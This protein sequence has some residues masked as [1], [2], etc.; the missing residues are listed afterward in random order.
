[1]KKIILLAMHGAPPRDFPAREMAELFS[2]HPRIEHAP[3]P[4]RAGLEQRY[5]ELD[6]RMRAWPRTAENDPFWAGTQELADQLRRVTGLEVV[7]GFNE[8]CAPTLDEA[9]DQ[10][11]ALAA[12]EV[13]VVTPM[14]TRG[15]EHSE[16]DIPAAVRAAQ[17]RHP[18][19][20]IRY[21]W[22]FDMSEV[23]QFLAAQI[24][25]SG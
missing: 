20:S 21:V 6:A 18:A 17:E 3:E 19:L 9:F 14:M 25:R 16:S 8:F 24:R 4:E 15:G 2:L 23:A 13:I 11:A 22:P 12:D 5:A 7:A 1:M 10:A